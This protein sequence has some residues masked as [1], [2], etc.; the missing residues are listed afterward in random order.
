LISRDI[1]YIF[2]DPAT[3]A[4]SQGKFLSQLSESK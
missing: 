3:L 4:N 2:R 1:L